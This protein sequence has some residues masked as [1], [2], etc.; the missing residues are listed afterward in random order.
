MKKDYKPYCVV[1]A[2]NR[3]KTLVL[4]SKENGQEQIQFYELAMGERLLNAPVPGGT[5]CKPKWNGTAW[6]ESATTEEIDTWKKE[7]FGHEAEMPPVNPGP[8]MS[9]RVASLESQMTDTQIALVENYEQTDASNTDLL[10]ATAEVYEN[11]LALQER[12]SALEGG[13]TNG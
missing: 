7:N 10:M 9:E 5:L 6:E 2:E 13:G 1:D 11:L 12:V 8:T 3:Y 4:A